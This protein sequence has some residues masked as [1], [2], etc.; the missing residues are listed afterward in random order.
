MSTSDLVSRHNIG[1]ISFVAALMVHKLHPLI[2]R[3]WNKAGRML[4]ACSEIVTSLWIR[5]VHQFL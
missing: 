4:S 2:V 5:A 3:G 1:G